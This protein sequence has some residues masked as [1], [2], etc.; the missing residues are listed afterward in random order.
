ME[1]AAYIV[2]SLSAPSVQGRQLPQLQ[3]LWSYYPITVFS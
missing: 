2:G 3:E 1:V